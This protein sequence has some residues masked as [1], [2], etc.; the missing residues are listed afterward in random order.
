M[1]LEAVFGSGSLSKEKSQWSTF[2][3]KKKFDGKFA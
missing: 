2:I 1:I 3:S